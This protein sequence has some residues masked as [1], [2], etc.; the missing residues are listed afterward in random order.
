MK[1]ALF[2]LMISVLSMPADKIA[3]IDVEGMTCPLCTVAVK[4]SLKKTPGVLN[5]KVK[6]NTHKAVV[7]FKDDVDTDALIEAIEKVGYKGKVVEVKA[8]K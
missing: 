7:R 4:K 1:R 5:A 3:V 6:L 2:T 8:K